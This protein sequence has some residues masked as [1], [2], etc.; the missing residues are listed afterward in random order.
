MLA[1]VDAP[2]S[3][4]AE[5]MAVPHSATASTATDRRLVDRRPELMTTSV[6]LTTGAVA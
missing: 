3:A 2:R 1:R 5:L 6:K 4:W